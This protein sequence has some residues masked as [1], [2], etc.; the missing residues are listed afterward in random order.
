MVHKEALAEMDPH[1]EGGWYWATCGRLLF[2][3]GWRAQ[4]KLPHTCVIH[5]RYVKGHPKTELLPSGR[6]LQQHERDHA[7][8]FEEYLNNVDAVYSKYTACVWKE[9]CNNA[10][11]AHI[12]AS[13]QYYDA[14][15]E[16]KDAALEA[17]DSGLDPND[18]FDYQF[19]IKWEVLDLLKVILAEA[20]VRRACN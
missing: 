19:W 20:A 17:E 15:K 11:S 7:K 6:T 10:R 16:V 12:S 3:P 2:C 1:V 9:S 8:I 4:L 14:L 18:S 13:R 5:I